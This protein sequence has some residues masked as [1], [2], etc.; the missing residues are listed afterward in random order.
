MLNEYRRKMQSTKTAVIH[1]KILRDA[2]TV[3]HIIFTS[4]PNRKP[5]VERESLH[6]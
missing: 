3:T 1:A 5:E 2:M 6:T 4:C